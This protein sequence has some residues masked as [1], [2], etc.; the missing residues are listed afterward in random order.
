MNSADETIPWRILLVEDDVE[1][2]QMVSDFLTEQGFEIAIEGNGQTAV[3]RIGSE[4]F[5]A[6]LLD[7]GLPE[8]DGISICRAV[9]RQFEGPILMLTARG[10]EIDEV[11]SFEVGADD[12]MAKP[13]S[14]KKSETI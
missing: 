6:L 12:Y 2:A 1:L 4:T 13:C 11:M 5:D 14:V 7:I 10:D 8:L 9:R 3:D